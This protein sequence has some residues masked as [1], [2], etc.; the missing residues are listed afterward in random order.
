[1]YDFYFPTWFNRLVSHRS[2]DMMRKVIRLR[3]SEFEEIHLGFTSGATESRVEEIKAD[4]L[5]MAKANGSDK[6]VKL[7]IYDREAGARENQWMNVLSSIG[8]GLA[9]KKEFKVKNYGYSYKNQQMKIF[10][11]TTMND[12]DP[13]AKENVNKITKEIE[14]FLSSEEVKNSIIGKETYELHITDKNKKDFKF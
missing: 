6:S 4:T 10:I 13:K 3:E 12:N 11:Y 14:D 9:A 5:E 8:D 2:I 1:M 7:D